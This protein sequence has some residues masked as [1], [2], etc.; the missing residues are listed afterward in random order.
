MSFINLVLA[1]QEQSTYTYQRIWYTYMKILYEF[2]LYDKTR[3][4]KDSVPH[5][6]LS[7]E[8]TSNSLETIFHLGIISL[9]MNMDY[10]RDEHL[11]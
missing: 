2:L 8:V 10:S 3:L 9:T 6:A 11:T 1:P 7:S 5:I 4:S